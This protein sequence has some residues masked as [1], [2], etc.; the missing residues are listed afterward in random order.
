MIIEW[1]KT[2]D[3]CFKSS[4]YFLN[5][6]QTF[7]IHCGRFPSVATRFA[8][9]LISAKMWG[10]VEILLFQRWFHTVLLIIPSNHTLN[11]DRNEVLFWNPEVCYS[12]RNF[13]KISLILVV[14]M[15]NSVIALQNFHQTTEIFPLI[16]ILNVEIHLK[17]SH[18]TVIITTKSWKQEFT[19]IYSSFKILQLQRG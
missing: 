13:I 16:K 8:N 17:K 1:K 3:W 10:A 4:H 15:L 6:E 18:N 2:F 12:W 7:L 11:Y 9:L 19:C 14:I 5:F